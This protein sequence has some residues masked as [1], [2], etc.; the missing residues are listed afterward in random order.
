MNLDDVLIFDLETSGLIPKGCKWNENYNEFP[1]IVSIA[2]L[3]KG[4]EEYHIIK[5]TGYDIPEES[6]KVHGITTEQALAQGENFA[7]V[8]TKFIQDSLNAGMICGHNIHFD[9]SIVKANILRYMG[10][11]F[12][13][14]YKCEDALFKGKRIDTMTSSM[15]W[16][17]ARAINGRLKFPNLT[18][19]Y[20]R[21]F[22]HTD[23]DAHNALADVKAVQACLPKLLENGLIK[24]E[25]KTYEEKAQES[26]N[27][28]Q[29]T[30]FSDKVDTSITESEKMDSR[31]KNE[32]LTEMLN[33]ND[34]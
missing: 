33:Q 29:E 14:G 30:I 17:D 1:Y 7:D 18:E 23:F 27:K 25:L 2:W 32:K 28:A 26:Q 3:F 15:K 24:L 34:F 20:H 21:C 11:N 5:P 9:T 8:I 10:Q 31:A 6:T 22:P 13:D 4:K 12:F 16:V 19:L